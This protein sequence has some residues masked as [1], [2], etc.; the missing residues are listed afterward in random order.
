MLLQ[1]WSADTN[2]RVYNI[3]RP[4]CMDPDIRRLQTG[5]GR[6]KLDAM[7][8]ERLAQTVFNWQPSSLGHSDGASELSHVSKILPLLNFSRT[9]STSSF[10]LLSS[11]SSGEYVLCRYEREKKVIISRRNSCTS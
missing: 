2:A 7:A 3:V 6:M 5:R 11:F 1:V 10:P 4:T 8:P 9:R